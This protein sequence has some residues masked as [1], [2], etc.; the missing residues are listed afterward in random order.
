[1]QALSQKK[2]Y[3]HKKGFFMKRKTI[4]VW[5]WLF[6]TLL[7]VESWAVEDYAIDLDYSSKAGAKYRISGEEME[8][9]KGTVSEAGNIVKTQDVTRI[10][11]F[12]G[13]VEVLAKSDN[14][15]K[16]TRSIK[17]EKMTASK[18]GS[19]LELLESGT[20]LKALSSKNVTKYDVGDDELPAALTEVL[21]K[22][23]AVGDQNEPS[24]NEV[25]GTKE[26]KK[27]GES[28]E[29]KSELALKFLG[30]KGISVNKEDVKGSVKLDE[31]LMVGGHKYLKVSGRLELKNLKGLMPSGMQIK[32]SEAEARFSMVSPVQMPGPTVDRNMDLT[33]KYQAEGKTSEGQ[34]TE[35]NRS[36]SNKSTVRY[37]YE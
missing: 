37:T 30:E 13:K 27:A 22:F 14:G 20:V 16:M 10:W 21:E 33:L 11:K 19:Q 28:W 32:S 18:N 5:F 24:D 36:F 29:M 1:M 9:K 8:V 2:A 3:Q 4:S 17:V 15:E 23:F 31:V 25:F 34:V 35:M 7:P 26:R 12:D 6:L